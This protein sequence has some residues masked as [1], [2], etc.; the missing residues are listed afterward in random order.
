MSGDL[1]SVVGLGQELFLDIRHGLGGFFLPG[2][3]DAF[4][5]AAENG[6]KFGV[7]KGGILLDDLRADLGTA[8]GEQAFDHRHP[9]LLRLDHFGGDAVG[10]EHALDEALM[11]EETLGTQQVGFALFSGKTVGDLGDERADQFFLLVDRDTQLT[12]EKGEQE[13]LVRVVVHDRSC[14]GTV[15]STGLADGKIGNIPKQSLLSARVGGNVKELL[16][17]SDDRLA[18]A[19]AG[20][21]GLLR[22]HDGYSR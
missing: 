18:A 16:N 4:H 11:G 6:E 13:F 5:Q 17:L 20:D 15:V 19:G 2:G 22:R 1:A 9:F 8:G 12:R 21:L 7:E 14:K 3:G 10:T